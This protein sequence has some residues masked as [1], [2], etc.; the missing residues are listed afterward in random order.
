MKTIFEAVDCTNEEMYFP[1]GLWT[2][3][4]DAIKDIEDC[5]EPPDLT[6]QDHE[7]SC[8][9]EIRER[10]MG[11]SDVGIKRAIIEWEMKYNEAEDQYQWE[12]KP[13]EIIGKL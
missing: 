13:V 9:V 7:E 3:L 6:D 11:F 5:Q 8:I 2:K 12:R 4:E 1:V 10:D